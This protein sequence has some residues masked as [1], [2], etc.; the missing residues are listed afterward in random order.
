MSYN[1]NYFTYFSYSVLWEDITLKLQ[2]QALLFEPAK[3]SFKT[4]N[5]INYISDPKD[6]DVLDPVAPSSPGTNSL[7]SPKKNYPRA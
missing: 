1:F 4:L 6:V 3:F 7:F 2:R 5:C